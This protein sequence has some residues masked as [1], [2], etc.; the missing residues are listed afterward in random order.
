MDRLEQITNEINAL[1]ERP[2]S[3]GTRPRPA[4]PSR[5]SRPS[6]NDEIKPQLDALTKDREI[7]VQEKEIE[8]LNGT[9]T[10]LGKVVEE[11]RE[12]RAGFAIGS[13]KDPRA[14]AWTDDPYFEGDAPARSVFATSSSPT[15]AA[16]TR[17]SA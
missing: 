3:G 8:A 13:V 17:A 11:L 4:T 1:N 10:D 16:P 15:R 2:R 7:A 6:S 12:P 9:V 14:R 5:R